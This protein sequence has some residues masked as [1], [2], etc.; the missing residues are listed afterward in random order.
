VTPFL[1]RLITAAAV[2]TAWVVVMRVRALGWNAVPAVTCGACVAGLEL[3][4]RWC[5]HEFTDH[6]PRRKN[7]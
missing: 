1:R 4:R 7:R 3:W 5:L 2:F 6:H